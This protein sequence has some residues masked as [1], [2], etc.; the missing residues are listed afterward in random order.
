MNF[1]KSSAM[2]FFQFLWT[3][4]MTVSVELLVIE[5]YPRLIAMAGN[6]RN[7]SITE[8][9]PAKIY[10]SLGHTTAIS[11]PSKPERMV[12]GAPNHV[13]VDFLGNDITVT[14]LAKN[15]GNLIVYTKSGRYVLLFVEGSASQYDDVVNVHL[16]RSGPALRLAKDSSRPVALNVDMMPKGKAAIPI[17]LEITAL[18]DSSGKSLEGT[19]LENTLKEVKRIQ[20]A[21]C[22]ISN[23]SGDFKIMCIKSI[24]E[25][26]C[27]SQTYSSIHIAR[28]EE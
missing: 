22:T 28:K 9:S 17:H 19:D 4:L 12:L 23:H 14:P 26:T 5:A 15:P 20:C 3:L 27:S 13:A 18:T 16:G 24:A 1:N 8:T 25:L 10:L 11:F 6:I 21:G 7:I 2:G